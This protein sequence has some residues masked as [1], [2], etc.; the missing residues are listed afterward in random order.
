MRGAGAELK[1]NGP[2][3]SPSGWR[4][5]LITPIGI[6]RAR[7]DST[8]IQSASSKRSAPPRL[9]GRMLS[10]SEEGGQALDQPA[11]ES[12]RDGGAF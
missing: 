5:Q 11:V 4:L 3:S 9:G 8:W 2:I 7:T 12:P 1:A 10:W 6:W